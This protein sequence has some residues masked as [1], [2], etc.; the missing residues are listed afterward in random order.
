MTQLAAHQESLRPLDSVEEWLAD[1][2][3]NNWELV[4]TAYERYASFQKA[5]GRRDQ[6]SK[7]AFTKRLRA[8]KIPDDRNEQGVVFQTSPAPQ[9]LKGFEPVSN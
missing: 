5:Q 8:L 3:G 1:R 2:G 7:K 4:A 6:I 9:L